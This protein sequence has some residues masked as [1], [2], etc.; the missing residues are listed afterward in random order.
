MKGRKKLPDQLKLVQ[1]TFRPHRANAGCGQSET[2]LTASSNL[3][4][5]A[6]VH[7]AVLKDS[8]AE[9]GL[10]S[11]TYNVV[12]ALAAERM[13]E[14]D[15][16]NAIIAAHGRVIESVTEVG[17]TL[18]RA[19]PAVVQRTEAMRHLQSLLAEFGLTPSSTGRIGVK[20]MQDH[21]SRAKGFADL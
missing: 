6:Q 1:G 9:L 8:V 18:L 17:N 14:I 11:S 12:L 21:A 16:C 10:D 2:P 19:N 7:F 15:E 5:A 3:S 4:E 20:K 13:A